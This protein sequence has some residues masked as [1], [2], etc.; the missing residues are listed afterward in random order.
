MNKYYFSYLQF[1]SIV[2]FLIPLAAFAQQGNVFHINQSIGNDGF[3]GSESAPFKTIQRC[4]R[5]AEAGDTCIVHQGTYRETIK[6]RYIGRYNAPIRFVV[7]EGEHVRVTGLNKVS[8]PWELYKGAIYKTVV[9]APVKQVFVADELMTLA[10]HPNSDDPFKPTFLTIND[11]QCLIYGTTEWTKDIQKCKPYD[12]D[13]LCSSSNSCWDKSF[14]KKKWKLESSGLALNTNWAGATLAVIDN[15]EYSAE[16]AIV[17]PTNKQQ[18]ISY[19]WFSEKKMES[20]I[21]F[22]L[23]NALAALDSDKEWFFN[24]TTTTLFFNSP[25]NKTPENIYVKVRDLAFDLRDKQYIVIE[26]FEVFAASIDAGGKAKGITLDRLNVLYPVHHQMFGAT[27]NFPGQ[28]ANRHK[29]NAMTMGKG[30]T[31]G[32]EGNVLKNSI[33][34]HSW[35]DGVTLYGKNNKVENN[36]ISD[37]NWGMTACSAV[38]TNGSFHQVI[39]NTLSDCGRS[40]LWHQMTFDAEFAYNDIYNACWLGLDCGVAGSYA[41]YGAKS[42]YSSDGDGDGDGTVYH[43]NWIHG[44]QNRD[45][46][47][48]LYLDNNE[49]EYLIHH[50]VVWGCRTAFALNDT[51]IAHGETGHRVFNNTCFNIDFRM[52]D[53]GQTNKWHLFG[54]EFKN[55]LCTTSR[56]EHYNNYSPAEVIMSHNVGPGSPNIYANKLNRAVGWSVAELY[57]Q[58]PKNNN[59]MPKASSPAVNRGVF[60]SEITTEV[61]GLPDVGAYE[62]GLLETRKIGF[63]PSYFK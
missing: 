8:S 1:F 31:L 59:F 39:Q 54:V 55:N 4:A 27:P 36:I 23:T 63:Q 41:W 17:L 3:N 40:C 46:G 45:G 21:K 56:D 26:G 30:V 11:T 35:C 25:G 34:S 48:C 7:A 15:A 49:Q 38:T 53:F 10:R 33:V 13:G 43:H 44:N 18:L 2:F 16:R 42:S 62:Y 60:I 57:L 5:D 28:G 24:K 47:V 50:N 20:G 37:V 12:E 14:S 58:D 32:G 52:S 51:F 19:E 61:D 6:P 29:V 22:Y 9:A